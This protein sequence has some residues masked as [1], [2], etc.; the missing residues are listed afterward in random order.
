MEAKMSIE[1]NNFLNKNRK[2]GRLNYNEFNFL[3]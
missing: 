2:K 3:I 1:F